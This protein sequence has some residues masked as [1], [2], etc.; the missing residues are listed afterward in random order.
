LP[1]ACYVIVTLFEGQFVTPHF[2]GRAMTLNPF[3]ILL[4][5]TLSL[6]LW[7]P[8]GGLV[9]GPSLLIVGSVLHY[10][11]PGRPMLPRRPVIRTANM[12][13]REE[14]LANAARAVRERQQEK[15]AQEEK[16]LLAS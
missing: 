6:W 9:S 2:L 10:V 5:T 14:I 15:A 4:V 1:V 11:L 13:D 3:M 16:G 7:G 12:T 8:V